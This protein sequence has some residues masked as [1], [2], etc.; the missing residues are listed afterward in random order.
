MK[1]ILAVL[2]AAVF[3]VTS[4]PLFATAADAGQGQTTGLN[5][6]MATGPRATGEEVVSNQ[7]STGNFPLM[8]NFSGQT[9]NAT[10]STGLKYLGTGQDAG[11]QY[12][13]VQVVQVGKV[14]D[15]GSA[16][17]RNL[18]DA[19]GWSHLIL[20]FDPVLFDNLNLDKCTITGSV[21]TFNF[22]ERAKGNADIYK[23]DEYSVSIPMNRIFVKDYRPQEDQRATLK[24]YLKDGH[25]L[26]DGANYL[27]EH[28]TMGKTNDLYPSIYIRDYI[29]GIDNDNVRAFDSPAYMQYT[30]NL[31]VPYNV[32]HKD[33]GYSSYRQDVMSNAYSD[34]YIDWNTNELHVNYV[35][36]TTEDIRSNDRTQFVQLFPEKLKDTL[37]QRNGV[38]AKFNHVYKRGDLAW[39]NDRGIAFT[40]LNSFAGTKDGQ[41]GFRLRTPNNVSSYNHNWTW[42]TETTKAY[43]RDLSGSNG[44]YMAYS[45]THGPIANHM[46]YY[47]DPDKFMKTFDNLDDLK[48]SSFFVTKTGDEQVGGVLKNSESI[49][50]LAV[51]KNMTDSPQIDDIY[52]DAQKITGKTGYNNADS[53]VFVTAKNFKDPAKSRTQLV[54]SDGSIEF[55]PQNFDGVFDNMQKDD[56]LS[57]ETIYRYANYYKSRPTIEKVKAR[58]IF[59]KYDG[60][61]DL[62]VTVP[63]SPKFRG[64]AGYEENGLGDKNMPENPKREGFIFK[65]WSTKKTTASE[66]AKAEKLTKLDQWNEGK[67]YQFDGTVPVNKSY[68]VYPVWEE[69]S[70]GITIVLHANDGTNREKKI[71][72]A[73][74]EKLPT[75]ATMEAIASMEEQYGELAKGHYSALSR[76]PNGYATEEG[77]RAV[78]GKRDGYNLVGWST[79][80]DTSNVKI[81]DLFS[82]MGMLAK[83]GEGKEGTYYLST[84]RTKAQGIGQA[85]AGKLFEKITPDKNN[86]VHLYA[87]WKPYFNIELTKQWYD[88]T[89]EKFKGKNVKEILQLLAHGKQNETPAQ[90]PALAEPIQIGLLYRTAVTEA[91]D[92]TIT[93]QANYYLVKGSLQNL[94]K[95]GGPLKWTLPSYDAYGKRLSYIAVEFEQGQS[96]AEK[97]NG[98]GQRWTNIWAT[99]ADNLHKKPGEVWDN[100]SISKVQSLV[101]PKGDGKVDAFSGATVRKLYENGSAIT[102]K[103]A[104]N[105]TVGTTPM[106]KTTFYNLKVNLANPTFRK[107]YDKDEE[108]KLKAP[109]DPRVQVVEFDLP[110]VD[111][112][113]TFQRDKNNPSKWNRVT[114]NSKGTWDASDK[115]NYTLTEIDDKGEKTLVLKLDLEGKNKYKYLKEGQ[116]VGA[117][118]FSLTQN[119]RSGTSVERVLKKQNAPSLNGLE[120]RKL[121]SKDG[122]EYVVIRALAPTKELEQFQAGAVL[123]L[124]D[125]SAKT[126]DEK[127]SAYKNLDGS[128][129]TATREGSYYV[130]RVPKSK[131]PDLKDGTNVAVYGEQDG[132][133]PSRSTIPCKVDLEGPKITADKLT[134]YVGEEVN[135]P[136]AITTDEDALLTSKEGLPATMALDKEQAT[137]LATK[138]KATGKAGDTKGTNTVNLVMEDKFGNKSEKD[139]TVEVV[140]RPTSDA[141]VKAEQIPNKISKDYSEYEHKILV[142][143]KEGAV[144]RVYLKEP[145]NAAVNAAVKNTLDA[146]EQEIVLSQ[147]LGTNIGEKVWITQEE[148]GKKESK[149]VEV[150]MDVTAPGSPAIESL[151]PGGKSLTLTGITEDTTKIVLRV[152]GEEKILTRDKTHK[153]L[154]KDQ[155]FNPFT[156][157]DGKL[158]VAFNT[159]SNPKEKAQVIVLDDMLN[160][161]SMTKMIEDYAAPTAPTIVAENKHSDRTTVSGK[162]ENPGAIVTIYKVTKVTDPETKEETEKLEKLG[163]AQVDDKGNYTTDVPYQKVGTE[164][165]A[166]ATQH[167]KESPLAKTTVTENAGIIPFDPTDPNPTPNP[168]GKRYVTVS[169]DANGGEFAK[170]TKSSF[171]VL[172]TYEVKP[173]DFNEARLG[174]EAPANKVFDK[175]TEDQAN[176]MA[177]TGKKFAEDATIYAGYK[178]N[179]NVIPFDP[180]DPNK[181]VNPDPNKYVTVSL[182]AN[183]GS[184]AQGTKSSFYVKKTYTMTT[185]DF[186]VAERGLI[187]PTDKAFNAWA[188]N[189]DGTEAFPAAG[190]KF[191]QDGSVF[192]QYREGRDVIPGTGNT[193][194]DG[195][196]TVTFT[197]AAEK[198]TLDGETTYYVNPKGKVKLGGLLA[199]TI[200]P[201]TGYAVSYPAWTY[202]ENQNAA[203]IV[204]ADTKAKASLYNKDKVIPVQDGVTV[205]KPDGYLDVVFNAGAN[206]K[207]EGT[208]KFYVKPGTEAKD[209][210]VPTPIPNTGYKVK[211]EVWN[212]TVPNPFNAN[213]ETTA[214]YEKL[215]AIS[216]TPQAGYVM[217]QFDGGD[218]GKV[219]AENDKKTILFVN[220]EV[221]IALS[222]KA[223]TVKADTNW[224][225]DKWSVDG[226]A[227]DLT[228]AAKY[229]KDT[230]IKA[231]YTSD[232]SDDSK[233]GFV[234]VQFKAG[235]KGVIESGN[236]NV[237]VKKDK[238]V[239]LTE[240]APKIKANEG[241]THIGWDKLLKDTFTET[242]EINAKYTDPSEISTKPV[243]GFKHITFKDGDRVKLEK[244]AVKEYWVNPNKVVSVPAPD[245]IVDAGYL[246]IGWSTNLTQQFTK[247]TEISPVSMES[248][249]VTPNKNDRYTEIQ[250]LAGNNGKLVGL[251]GKTTYSLWAN[252]DKVVTMQPPQIDAD[253]GWQLTG[254]L[255]KEDPADKLVKVGD[256]IKGQFPKE[257]GT[258]QYIAQYKKLEAIS[259]KPEKGYVAITFNA[260]SNAHFDGQDPNKR[261]ITYY[262]N[263]TANKSFRDLLKDNFQEP[264]LVYEAGYEKG[265]TKWS[266]DLVLDETITGAKEFTANVKSKGVVGTDEKPEPKNWKTVEFR[267][268]DYDKE[269]AKITGG[270]TKYKVDPNE[271]VDLTRK[272][273]KVNVKEGYSLDGWN[274]ALK[275]KF[276]K[277]TVIYA[278]I[279]GDISTTQKDGFV[280]VNFAPGENGQFEDGSVTKVY[281]RKNTEVDLGARAPKVIA[282]KNYSHSGWKI[283]DQTYGIESI[284]AKFT[285]DKNTI[286][287]TYNQDIIDNPETVDPPNGYARVQFMAGANGSFEDGAKTNFDVRIAAGLTIGDLDKPKV[288]PDPGFFFTKWD[289]DNNTKITDSMDVTAQYS[290]D[291]IP[292]TDPNIKPKEGYV[293]ITFDPGVNGVFSKKDDPTFYDV[294]VSAE[295]HLSDLGKP[296]VKAN[297]GYTHT[298][299]DKKDDA[300]LD[301]NMIV[302]AQ[303]KANVITNPNTNKPVPEGYIRV[304]FNATEKGT[305]VSGTAVQDVLI[306]ANKTLGDLSKPTVKGI[307]SNVFSG[308]DKEDNT[309]LDENIPNKALTVT[310]QYNDDMKPVDD[311]SSNIP[312]GYA[313]VVFIA[314]ENGTF[315]QGE[316]TAYDVLIKK[317]LKRTLGEVKKPKVKANDGYTFKAW[318]TADDK[319]L[320]ADQKLEVK[321]TYN[322]NVIITDDPNSEIP[323][324]YVR[325]TFKTDGKG[326]MTATI[327]SV[328]KT[329][330]SVVCMDVLPKTKTVGELKKNVKLTVSG[331]N[332]FTGWSK[333][334]DYTVVNSVEID[335]QYKGG[336]TNTPTATALNVGKDNFTT[337]K[338]TAEAGAKVVA[339][340]NG[341]VVGETEANKDGDYIIKATT[342]DG[343]KLPENTEVIVTATKAPMSESKPQPVTVLPDANGDGKA[344]GDTQAPYAPF[345]K[346]PVADDTSIVVKEPVEKDAKKITIL[347]NQGTDFYTKAEAEKD[348]EGWKVNGQKVSIDKDGW[349][350]IPL[351]ANTALKAEQKVTANVV[352]TS[353]N[354]SAA[355]YVTVRDK[356]ESAKPT[357]VKALNQNEVV[358]GNIT[359]KQKPTTT[360]TGKAPAGSTV[361]IKDESDNE[362]GKI[363]KVPDSGEFTAEVKK[364]NENA[365]VKVTAQEPGKKESKPEEVTVARDANNDGIDD[366]EFSGKPTIV[367]P[368]KNGDTSVEVKGKEGA[369]AYVVITDANGNETKTAPTTLTPGSD[370]KLKITVPELKEGQTVKVVQQEEGKKPVESDK[371]VVKPN[372]DKLDKAIEDGEKVKDLNDDSNTDQALKK[373]IE[374]GKK[375]SEKAK[376]DPSE[377]SQ[378]K[379]DAAEKAIRDALKEKENFEDAK[380]K[381]ADAKKDLD[382]KDKVQ[383]AQD[384]IDKMKGSIDPKDT[385]NYNKDKADLQK[386]LDKAKLDHVIKKGDDKLKEEGLDPTDKDKLQKAVDEGKKTQDNLNDGN[387]SNDPDHN[388]IKED[389][390]AIEDALNPKGK[391]AKPTIEKANRGE[392]TVSGTAAPKAEIK[393]T[394]TPK[395]GTPKTFKGEADASGKYDVTTQ[396]LVD[397]DK[398]VVTASE[399]GK[400]DNESDPKIVGVDTSKL[401]ESIDKADPIAGEK[402]KDTGKYKNLD[403]NNPIDKALKDAL[404]EGKK[405]KDLG[406][407]NDSTI[408]QGK[409]DKAKEDL[410]K[411]IAQ[412]EADKAVDKAKDKVLDPNATDDDKNT[413][414]KDAQDKIDAI[415]G[416]TDPSDTDNY[417]PIKKDLQD[418]LDLIKKIKEGDDRLKQDDIKDKPKQDVDDLKKAVE[419][420][421]KA[422]DPKENKSK[423]DATKTIEK[424]LN[425]IN[426]ERII[427]GV[428][429]LAVGAKTLEIK[430]SVPRAT[431]VIKIAGVEIGKITTDSFGTFSKGLRDELE[432]GQTV[433]LEASKTGYNDGS[434]SDTVY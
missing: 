301:A 220:P 49:N 306:A 87:A 433:A 337:I 139:W 91:N 165:G 368:I 20:H 83:D 34:V 120:Q 266:P 53:N 350:T 244:D 48:F 191:E 424:A 192:A 377:S 57:F 389:I 247:D 412:K 92:P 287:A 309:K 150:P 124:F 15:E 277:D 328:E 311:P 379:V 141:V 214:Q 322:Q 89:S 186:A 129:V 230:V 388:K 65:G 271:T 175:W 31:N 272:T 386:E 346:E 118:Y 325:A 323:E 187:P 310:A 245:V 331:D 119:D 201:A 105:S 47:I 238:E 270:M 241:Y 4:F 363:D 18:H 203:S 252:P 182:N 69:E 345:V 374:A 240:K 205:T 126:G 110:E 166:V 6:L 267:I 427:V 98:F 197:A 61:K 108:V 217:V 30:G 171:Y 36:E 419:D 251:N 97:Y 415:P 291:I 43:G 155:D 23:T 222:D 430:T 320:V 423:T 109:E 66:F 167:G 143:G 276:E 113:I 434:F 324:G 41:A 74:D 107:L 146:A 85:A 278:L 215:P 136:S 188:L 184:F 420:G 173:A 292:G 334:D 409:V 381:V 348:G 9:P 207:L 303:Y 243:A 142:K 288:N 13:N 330:L 56:K 293:R 32:E 115:T 416:S 35:Y 181:P 1:K 396:T 366:S 156:L 198:A 369:T 185:N 390:K 351:P 318:D 336:Q 410:D 354:K 46:V 233:D 125:A 71:E 355:T 100:T 229:A 239:D 131:N 179:D 371:V 387:A 349:M 212:P 51:T 333:P 380:K 235:D 260:G 99:V 200:K 274:H 117:T 2:I 86:E 70:K 315:E 78:F 210:P 261:I 413:A 29:M 398:V 39:G 55:Y 144:I 153:D 76:L 223:P 282:N 75:K 149:A 339:K 73:Y 426:M 360:V 24:L 132:Y 343:K 365:K 316:T 373:A 33:P 176:K 16:S 253:Q 154:W 111:G 384:A 329:N 96:G 42:V 268:F 280:E 258:V 101:V 314:G 12:I 112:K 281:V 405:V 395:N 341:E 269:T 226:A 313:R 21:G 385:D 375:E 25:T 147:G 148:K 275:G 294:R 400:T 257:N 297:D 163:I 361:I 28:R 45:K 250:F 321:A 399:T 123:T 68:R 40:N 122:E 195:Y 259:D 227:V 94:E 300:L 62:S 219:V 290:G 305:I 95:N 383:A 183:G 8:P 414:I 164:V 408:D 174:L 128:D 225:F 190:K 19:I 90:D 221:E 77:Q 289:K 295:K 50:S 137:Q 279:G 60:D 326:T 134:V 178:A 357:D 397:G 160:P 213:F 284:K 298:G 255:K 411:A 7:W 382:N 422:L 234:L 335:A 262:V 248:T 67:A 5:A 362:I 169:L 145:D 237:Y 116:E 273:P 114:A 404:D 236:A 391:T 168:D 193:K 429:S 72:L 180:N 162:S 59:D 285:E 161:R 228:Q 364:Q 264:D 218:H 152:G 417:N 130:F 81:E 202:S 88:S 64:E 38:Y 199:P 211:A 103:Q 327:N 14:Y 52:T 353:N 372:T 11:G 347:V 157:K 10:G 317:D 242:T 352:D 401:K 376:K 302:T 342:K 189:Q 54:N 403:E 296:T 27:I 135:A 308:W 359:D 158:E 263:P 332:V 232:I 159:V 231:T 312:K 3:L 26:Q 254:W 102:E 140:D 37:V 394:V 44:R 428:D 340:V 22:S 418:K 425:Q 392:T 138:W 265:D 307:G 79:Q 338:G 378:A 319:V 286:T 432:E 170:G 127:K 283:G 406:D 393:V 196:V 204:T 358:D 133:N 299:W 370:G 121:E 421:K 106:Y 216:D 431:V 58:I 208:S 407:K 224:S 17:A 206:G 356:D 93:G 249:D 84:V 256:A 104:N 80:A 177:F 82:N 402:D 63:S 344:D 151:K 209:V 304:S 367:T 194:P 246:H 172:K